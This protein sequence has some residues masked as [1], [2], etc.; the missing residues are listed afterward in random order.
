MA[1]WRGGRGEAGWRGRQWDK[2]FGMEVHSLRSRLLAGAAIATL[3][4]IAIFLPELAGLGWHAVYGKTAKYDGWRIPVPNGWFAMRHG[5]SL[6]LERML[7]I[8]LRQMTPTVVF[9]PMHT[10]KNAP[11]NAN[12]WTQV[13]VAIQNRRGYELASTRQITMIGVPGY[14]W[15]F[16]KRGDQSSWWIT[17]LAPSEDLSADY[18]GRQAYVGAFYAILPEIKR[19]GGES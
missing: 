9:L 18:S 2:L 6:T 12:I 1:I 15:E 14:C 5:E 16:V 19:S 11:F 4:G 8:P 7:H 3:L 10:K 17:C 13:Q